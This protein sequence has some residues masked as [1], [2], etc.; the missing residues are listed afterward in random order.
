MS[1]QKQKGTVTQVK[2]HGYV[3]DIYSYIR[4]LN[5]EGTVPLAKDVGKHFKT[6][7]PASLRGRLSDLVRR[8]FIFKLQVM[9]E[10]AR[11]KVNPKFCVTGKYI[12]KRSVTCPGCGE[13]FTVEPKYPK[14]FT[15]KN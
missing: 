9:N 11:Y 1:L 2:M 13:E 4:K 6:I 12:E 5:H 14:R 10:P 7:K 8:K 15:C 3:L